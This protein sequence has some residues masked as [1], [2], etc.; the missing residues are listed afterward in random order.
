MVIVVDSLTT[1]V[2]YCVPSQDV[3]AHARPAGGF[4]GAISPRRESLRFALC[5]RG[6]GKGGGG[7][8][9]SVDRE[10]EVSKSTPALIGPLSSLPG[11][12]LPGKALATMYTVGAH[13]HAYWTQLH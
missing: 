10:E 3:H 13:I 8:G 5:F 11:P 2:E 7:E 6:R 1:R 9:I 4:N 12:G